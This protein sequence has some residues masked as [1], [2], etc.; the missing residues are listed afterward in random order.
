MNFEIEGWRTAFAADVIPNRTVMV[1]IFDS[2]LGLF[3]GGSFYKGF[4]LNCKMNF[5]KF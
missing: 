3:P 1:N 2:Q 5:G 4:S